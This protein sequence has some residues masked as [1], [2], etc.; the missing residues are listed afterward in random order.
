MESGGSTSRAFVDPTSMA[1]IGMHIPDNEN[2]SEGLNHRPLLNKKTTLALLAWA[3][4]PT[5]RNG[6]ARRHPSRPLHVVR[7][8]RLLDLE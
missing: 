8:F 3:D 4:N 6:H 1:A 7:P 2:L 5:P